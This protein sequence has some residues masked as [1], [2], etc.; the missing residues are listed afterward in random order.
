MHIGLL[1]GA[2]AFT[3]DREVRNKMNYNYFMSEII[4][5]KISTRAVPHNS[6][7]YQGVIL[8][9]LASTTALSLK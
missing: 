8:D 1:K 2:G 6:K 3:I 7:K 9:F 5:I 4:A